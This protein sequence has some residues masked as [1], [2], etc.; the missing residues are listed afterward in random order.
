MPVGADIRN[1]QLS[2]VSYI[3]RASRLQQAAYF[4]QPCLG[5]HDMFN[6][7]GAGDQIELP[8]AREN[9]I[10]QE[11]AHPGI[12]RIPGSLQVQSSQAAESFTDF[13]TRNIVAEACESSQIPAIGEAH[14]QVGFPGLPTALHGPPPTP[15][16]LRQIPAAGIGREC[17][18]ELDSKVLVTSQERLDIAD[19]PV[20]IGPQK[21][22]EGRM[23]ELR[24]D[25][26]PVRDRTNGRSRQAV[27]G[28]AFR[29]F[30]PMRPYRTFRQPHAGGF[31]IR[32]RVSG[33][34]H[35]RANWPIELWAMRSEEHTSELQSPCNLVCRL[36]LE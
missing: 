30:T 4:A 28:I 20:V 17:I 13:D 18:V 29:H 7:I 19:V 25:T 21:R 31:R 15:Q 32:I 3:C 35:F 2:R 34:I 9:L 23:S 10:G 22:L 36:L 8:F 33:S 12:H 11:V 24:M 6:H 5:V 27:D 14:I 26:I 16:L 1:A